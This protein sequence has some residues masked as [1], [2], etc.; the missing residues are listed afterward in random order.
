MDFQKEAQLV[1]DPKD[2]LLVYRDSLWDRFIEIV[3]G[4]TS[5]LYNVH[6]ENPKYSHV[7]KWLWSVHQN[8]CCRYQS[9]NAGYE[10]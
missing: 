1:F 10:L 7:L 8:G 9:Y 5:P 6:K 3:Y 2:S 4:L